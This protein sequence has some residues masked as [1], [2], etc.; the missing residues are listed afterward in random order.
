[1][2]QS[3]T[4]PSGQTAVVS[5]PVTVQTGGTV[6]VSSN[7]TITFQ[8]SQAITLNPGFTAQAGSIFT[9][10]IITPDSPPAVPTSVSEVSRNSNSISLTWTAPT[11]S[12][13]IAGYFVYRNGSLVGSSTY[14]GFVDT[15]LTVNTN[16]S[17][18]V[19]AFD[20]TGS[21]SGNSSNYSVATS[22]TQTASPSLDVLAPAP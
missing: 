8:G 16:Y 20:I 6:S 15:G 11:G 10:K 4:F 21:L 2:I 18:T 19:V 22:A 14:A 17:Y 3:Y 9:A 13:A 12:S 1:V 5:G 7:A